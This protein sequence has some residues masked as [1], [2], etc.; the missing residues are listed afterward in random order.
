MTYINA[1]DGRD[2]VFDGF[3]VHGRTATAASLD[4]G[5]SPWPARQPD[6]GRVHPVRP[7]RPVLVL[8]TETDQVLLGGG[9]IGQPDAACCATGNWR[10]P[11]TPTP[12]S[13]SPAARTTARCRPS[14]WLS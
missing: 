1:I 5:F 8:Q 3:A 7:A 6:D 11:L 14:G 10:A 4:K 13:W 9:Q 12:T 2:Q